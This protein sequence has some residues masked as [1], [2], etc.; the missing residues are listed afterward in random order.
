MFDKQDNLVIYDPARLGTRLKPSDSLDLY[1]ELKEMLVKLG[2]EEELVLSYK[3]MMEMINDQ[4]MDDIIDLRESS[5]I[6]TRFVNKDKFVAKHILIL[7]NLLTV[8]DNLELKY[9]DLIGNSHIIFTKMSQLKLK[10]QHESLIDIE[11]YEDWRPRDGHLIGIGKEAID[12]L[13]LDY[14]DVIKDLSNIICEKRNLNLVETDLIFYTQQS[15]DEVIDN[16]KY[17]TCISLGK[18]D[19]M[20]L[21]YT[22]DI[23]VLKGDMK[24]HEGDIYINDSVK[25]TYED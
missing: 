16:D 17:N 18:E 10:L 3:D 1:D 8:L 20:E 15:K 19:M 5:A 23:D 24:L 13:L 9:K 14:K 12:S 4:A 25:V 6:S 21:L 11:G 22:D 2:V 7:K